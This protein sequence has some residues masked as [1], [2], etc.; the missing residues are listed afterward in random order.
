METVKENV[1]EVASDITLH[2]LHNHQIP[3]FTIRTVARASWDSW[4]ETMLEIKR[5][6]PQN[7]PFLSLQDNLYPG[8]AFT[9]TIRR[10]F[11]IQRWS[12]PERLLPSLCSSL[13]GLSASQTSMPVYSS[14][15]NKD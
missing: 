13:C 12:C 10:L 4:L 9:P 5:D 3:Y 8:A 1:H 11:N 6:W 15:L 14:L 2:W 7:R